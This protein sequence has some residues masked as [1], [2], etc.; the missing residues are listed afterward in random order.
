ME[1]ASRLQRSRNLYV[2]LLPSSVSSI[3]TT[4]KR[5]LVPVA[6]PMPFVSEIAVTK[7]STLIATNQTLAIS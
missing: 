1:L 7:L 6:D 2:A 5:P 4:L 3:C